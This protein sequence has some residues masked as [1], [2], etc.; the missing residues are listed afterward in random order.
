MSS[1][2]DRDRDGELVELLEGLFFDAGELRRFTRGVDT[3]LYNELP[4][5]MSLNEL[6]FT[7]VGKA[8]KRGLVDDEFFVA[9]R[10]K[11]PKRRSDIDKV[12][13][14]WSASGTDTAE[15]RQRYLHAIDVGYADRSTLTSIV[16]STSE[17]D[18]IVTIDEV[19]VP[20]QLSLSTAAGTNTFYQTSSRTAAVPDDEGDAGSHQLLDWINFA[21]EAHKLF[22]ITGE[23]GSGKTELMYRTY[24]ELARSASDTNTAPLPL[25]IRARDLESGALDCGHLAQAA[26]GELFVDREGLYALLEDPNMHWVYLI[27]GLDEANAAVWR[28]VRVLAREP[29][30]RA[31]AVIVTSRPPGV[32]FRPN[33]LVLSLPRWNR[34]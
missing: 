30:Y 5:D 10:Q 13:A 31:T 33:E 25:Y 23:M 4:N 19:Y 20:P 8:T 28:Q 21:Q 18:E 15:Q 14:L 1:E 9:L 27:D 29:R 24:L 22:I 16:T 3:D 7:L 11:R 17:M 34:H 26:A 12:A 2:I 6:A 32:I